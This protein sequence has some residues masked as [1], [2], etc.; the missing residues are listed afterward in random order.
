MISLPSYIFMNNQLQ[1][2][3][4]ADL[5]FHLRHFWPRKSFRRPRFQRKTDWHVQISVAVQIGSWHKKQFKSRGIALVTLRCM[6]SV[7]SSK[8]TV[9]VSSSF[10]AFLFWEKSYFLARSKKPWLAQCYM[11]SNFWHLKGQGKFLEILM[12]LS[13]VCMGGTKTQIPHPGDPGGFKIKNPPPRGPRG[14]QHIKYPTP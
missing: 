1:V 6:S 4:K 10:M 14:I 5:N 3:M 2:R 12:I 9:C 7:A 8:L 11:M 13:S